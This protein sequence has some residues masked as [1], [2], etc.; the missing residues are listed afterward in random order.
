[1]DK[2]GPH[3]SRRDFLKMAGVLPSSLCVRPR[4]ED[5][6][7]EGLLEERQFNLFGSTID[8]LGVS[9]TRTTY[10]N[11]ENL[12]KDRIG[13]SDLVI[14]EILFFEPCTKKLRSITEAGVGDPSA[15]YF[16]ENIEKLTASEGKPIGAVDPEGF[17]LNLWDN[18]IMPLLP[19]VQVTDIVMGKD[20]KQIVLNELRE[21]Y[22][23]NAK[24]DIKQPMSRKDFLKKMG[25]LALTTILNY[26]YFL[27][28]DIRTAVSGED[29]IKAWSYGFDDKFLPDVFNYRNIRSGQ[30][31]RK[32]CQYFEKIG[33]KKI[34]VISGLAHMYLMMEYAQ[35][36]HKTEIALKSLPNAFYDI[37]GN[38]SVR[39]YDY[40]KQREHWVKR[41]EI[42]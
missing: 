37:L 1:M 13:K 38:E 9:H 25:L 12:F 26:N 19:W 6:F 16:Y 17:Y 29:W 33:G 14:S 3:L 34:T 23:F 40:D 5:K 36:E 28:S 30:G 31:I 18:L 22:H 8:F 41:P 24:V 10:E 42:S 7:D 11:N 15:L 39:I 4:K 2:L 21:K 20:I 35:N 27:V 32:L